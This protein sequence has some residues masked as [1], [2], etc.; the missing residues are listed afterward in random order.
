M[1]ATLVKTDEDG[2]QKPVYFV[3]KMLTHVESHYTNFERIALALRVATKKQCP[4]FQAHTI[5]VL[6]SYLIRAILHMPDSLGRLLKWAIELCEFD[7][8]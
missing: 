4:Y 6:S 8:V 1:S 2:G 5:N 7:I 3:S